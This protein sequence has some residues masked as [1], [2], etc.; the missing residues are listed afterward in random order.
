MKKKKYN[1]NN[2]KEMSNKKIENPQER[3]IIIDKKNANK[4]ILKNV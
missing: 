4:I 3:T 2:I 1:F